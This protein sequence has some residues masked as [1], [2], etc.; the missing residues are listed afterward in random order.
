M[1]AMVLETAGRP[2]QPVER[3]RPAPGPTELLIDVEAC[4]VCRTDLH[5]V[6]GEL[7]H[8]SRMSCPAMRSSAASPKRGAA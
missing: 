5:V 4:G 8:P 2:L 3:A 7:P 6:D 1:R